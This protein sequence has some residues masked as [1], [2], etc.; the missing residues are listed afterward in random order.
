MGGDELWLQP[1]FDAKTRLLT[2]A[3]PWN[4]KLGKSG[5]VEMLSIS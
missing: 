1:P 2:L 3:T 4:A 5:T